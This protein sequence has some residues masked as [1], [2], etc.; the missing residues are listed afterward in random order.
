MEKEL[1]IHIPKNISME[2]IVQFVNTASKYESDVIIPHEHFKTNAK[3]L[4]SFSLAIIK[5]NM[6]LIRAN[7]PDASE[8][9]DH[10]SKIFIPEGKN[11]EKKGVKKYDTICGRN[12]WDNAPY[13][14]NRRSCRL[15]ITFSLLKGK[16]P[17]IGNM[18]GFQC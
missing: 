15:P 7:G 3:S 9:I 16:D 14:F 18:P 10:L 13:D 5:S 1:L 12:G 4:L 6:I 8:A 17:P 2:K 11:K